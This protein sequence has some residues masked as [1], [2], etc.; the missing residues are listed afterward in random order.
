[1]STFKGKV[2]VVTGGSSGIG[3]ATA[4]LFA[5][6]GATVFITGRR[7]D[8]LK[9]AATELGD[10]VIAVRADCTKISDLKNLF[11]TVRKYGKI[12]VLFANAGIAEN[13]RIGEITE[14]VFDR[15]FNINVKGIV[16]TVQ[17]AL[18]LLKNGSSVILTSSVVGRKGFSDSSIY[19]A[20]KAA[21]RSLARTWTTDLKDR[22]IRVNAV[23]P[24]PIET[25]ALHNVLVGVPP[26]A[27]GATLPVGHIGEPADIASAV[28]FLA[29]SS[30]IAGADIQVDGGGGQV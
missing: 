5:K 2:V 1:M 29:T 23:S 10:N 12:D 18:P 24:G 20:T 28:Y 8:V 25:P 26:D 15:L 16:F 11:E 27:L 7:D 3:Y 9:K 13:T 19:S 4:K 30:F 21:I 17:E 14:E 6:D 22:G